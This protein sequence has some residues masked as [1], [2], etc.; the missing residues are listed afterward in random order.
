ML[1][2]AG[3]AHSSAMGTKRRKRP[4]SGIIDVDAFTGCNM[5]AARASG[6]P[7]YDR[8][9]RQDQIERDEYRRRFGIN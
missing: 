8:M 1:R 2:L 5:T 7:D 4:R 9:V 6:S 3:S